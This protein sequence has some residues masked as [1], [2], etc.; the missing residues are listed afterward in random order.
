MT[1][2]VTA[3]G[4]E[5]HLRAPQPQHLGAYTVAWALA[6][7]NRFTGHAV[8]PYSVAEHSLL[9]CEIAERECGLSDAHG[10]MACLLHDA[11]EAFCGDMHSPGK[12]LIDGWAAWEQHWEH[13]VRRAFD[14]NVAASVFRD[15]VKRADLIALA[16]ERKA[17]LHPSAKTP[18]AVLAEVE[19]VTWVDLQAPE[20]VRADWEFWRDRFLDRLHELEFARAELRCPGSVPGTTQADAATR[21]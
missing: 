21:S 6:Q 8:R 10:L 7:I 13:Q 16:T 20:R 17:L 19:P 12:L 14:I 1:F 9:V 5:L 18:W 4:N 2:I 3:E 11:H 15:T